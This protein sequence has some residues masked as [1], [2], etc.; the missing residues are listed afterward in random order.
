MPDVLFVIVRIMGQA[1]A[2]WVERRFNVFHIVAYGKDDLNDKGYIVVNA[3]GSTFVNEIHLVDILILDA[4][5]KP[6][7]KTLKDIQ[8]HGD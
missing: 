4:F 6:A 8:S 7:R 3:G 1:Q 2:G 5:T